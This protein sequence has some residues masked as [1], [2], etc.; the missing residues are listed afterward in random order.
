MENFFEKTMGRHACSDERM[1]RLFSQENG[2]DF[3]F[4]PPPLPCIKLYGRECLITV[5]LESEIIYFSV[6]FKAFQKKLT[7]IDKHYSLLP[8]GLWI[9]KQKVKRWIVYD[10][11][12]G[13]YRVL[14][15]G[16][17]PQKIPTLS[18]SVQITSFQ[19]EM[20]CTLQLLLAQTHSFLEISSFKYQ[21]SLRLCLFD[22]V[23]FLFF[24]N[25]FLGF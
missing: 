14:F 18:R 19:K 22:R 9:M 4:Y 16:K 21:I 12:H 23:L 25:V 2:D 13:F 3:L 20:P 1:N 6:I 11:S 7:M 24:L 8:S 5:R 15:E 10:F 17:K